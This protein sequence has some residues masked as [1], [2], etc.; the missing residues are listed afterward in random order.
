MDLVVGIL[1]KIELVVNEICNTQIQFSG[2]NLTLALIKF[3]EIQTTMKSIMN[4]TA[5]MT[6]WKTLM[7]LPIEILGR[8]RE[9]VLQHQKN[10]KNNFE[11]DFDRR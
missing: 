6:H 1:C 5:K 9:K 3:R 4:R 7:L 11:E 10:K 2:R 8:G